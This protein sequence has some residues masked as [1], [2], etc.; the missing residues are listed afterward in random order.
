MAESW[1]WYAAQKWPSFSDRSQ[2]SI[3]RGANGLR[4]GTNGTT[5]IDWND[6]NKD[7]VISD[8][9]TDDRVGSNGDTVRVGDATKTVKEIGLYQN[10]E[11]TAGG[12][13][14]HVNIV[15]TVF[16][17]GTYGTRLIDGEFPKG[18]NMDKV[19]GIRLGTWDGREYSGLYT[20]AFDD[21]FVCF[22]EGTRIDTPGGAVAIETLRP[23]MMVST[24]DH[25]P[26]P[27]VWVGRRSVCGTGR[28][29]PIL[30]RKG[31]LGNS[32]DLRVSPQHRMLISGWRAE[33][34]FGADE[35]L[36][37]AQHL[38]DGVT[39]LRAPCATVTYAHLL[40]D[41]HEIVRSEGIASESFHPGIVVLDRL[42]AAVRDEILSIFPEIL[43][44]PG[45]A[46]TA[47]RCL[48]GRE[49]CALLAA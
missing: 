27:L 32:A 40:F 16:T 14:Y 5:R 8:A 41:Q 24:L 46:S 36:V 21:R 30:I 19:T 1:I 15:V 17:D 18:L 22:A 39:I 49:A 20:S 43:S 13:T 48:T 9:D 11:I 4:I 26:R 44:A 3:G 38:T 33:L 12:Q 47:R 42:G 25:G 10:C 6:A 2:N 29:A 28:M 37:A 7:G 31:A 34:L 45:H 35:V 23:G